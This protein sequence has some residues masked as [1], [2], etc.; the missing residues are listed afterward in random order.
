MASAFDEIQFPPSISFGATGGPRFSTDVLILSSGYEAR[1]QNWAAARAQYDISTGIKT[2]ADMDAVI[3]F[4]YARAGRAR[5][6]RYKDWKDFQARAQP[7]LSLGANHYQLAK[8][9]S[10]GAQTYLRTIAKP[11]SA[12][13][14]CYVGTTPTVPS[15]IDYTTGIVTSSAALTSADF[16]FDVPVRFDTDQLDVEI[17]D[18]ATLEFAS[19]VRKIPLVEVR[20]A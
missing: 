4:F 11:V 7:L 9:Y 5:G 6:F 17:T 14:V 12:T 18:F 15:A 16:D 13:V 8:S 3:A 19:I 2:K 10:S 1:N 20:I